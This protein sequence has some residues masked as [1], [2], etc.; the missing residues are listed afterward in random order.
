VLSSQ[1]RIASYTDKLLEDGL[2][3]KGSL[4]TGYRTLNL[5]RPDSNST[6]YIHRELAKLFI[7]RPSPQHKYVIHV[8]HVKTD[9]SIKKLAWVTKDEMIAHQQNSPAKLAYKKQLANRI[10]GPKLNA[11]QVKNIKNLLDN[12][13]RRLTNK[14]IADK[15]G[16]SEMSLYRIKRGDA[17]AHI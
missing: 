13:N 1:G 2:I 5:H 15:F 6:L 10:T 14:Q 17:W 8:N 9:N 16:I 11:T 7:K 12:K 4:T 3:L